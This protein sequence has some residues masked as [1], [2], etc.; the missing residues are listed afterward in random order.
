M[1]IDNVAAEFFYEPGGEKEKKSGKDNM[2]DISG[3]EFGKNDFFTFPI[4]FWNDDTYDRMARR[5]LE[6]TGL[7]F[8]GNDKFDLNIRMIIEI[9]ADLIRVTACTGSK[10]C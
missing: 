6:D 4:C 2:R 8:V 9:S 7:W 1:N 5:N 3:F 10:D